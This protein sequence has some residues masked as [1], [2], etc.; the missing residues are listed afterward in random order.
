MSGESDYGHRIP[1]SN[2]TDSEFNTR[3]KAVQARLNVEVQFEPTDLDDEADFSV[4]LT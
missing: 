2:T 3:G 4:Y 1:G